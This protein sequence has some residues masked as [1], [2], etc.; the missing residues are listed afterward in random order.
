MHPTKETL[1]ALP[2]I[3]EYIKNQGLVADVVSN[4]I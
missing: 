3:L 1:S 2:R 4:V